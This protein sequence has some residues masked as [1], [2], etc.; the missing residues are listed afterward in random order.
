MW[1]QRLLSACMPVVW[2]PGRE[3][4][5]TGPAQRHQPL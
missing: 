3:K 2:L 4:Y 1:L 5:P